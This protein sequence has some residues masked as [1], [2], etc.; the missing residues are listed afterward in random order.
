MKYLSD[1][2]NPILLSFMIIYIYHSSDGHERRFNVKV[3]EGSK[4]SS[5]AIV[6][7]F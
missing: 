3:L 4:T 2:I 6:E 1:Q 5:Q 7:T